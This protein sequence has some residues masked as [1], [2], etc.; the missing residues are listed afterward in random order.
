[1]HSKNFKIFKGRSKIQTLHHTKWVKI[2]TKKIK[3][4]AYA[5]HSVRVFKLI[6]PLKSH[7]FQKLSSVIKTYL[8]FKREVIHIHRFMSHFK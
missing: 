6:V 1:M 3:T 8:V 7:H 5:L 2:Q 4:S